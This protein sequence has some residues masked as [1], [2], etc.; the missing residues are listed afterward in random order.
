[1]SCC[2]RKRAAMTASGIDDIEES[3]P[4]WLSFAGV[5]AIVV[6]G[7]ATGRYYRFAP[8]NRLRVHASDAPSMREIPGLKKTDGAQ[9]DR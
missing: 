5:R 7:P 1:M 9:M 3:E 6:K 8:G 2:G 4:I